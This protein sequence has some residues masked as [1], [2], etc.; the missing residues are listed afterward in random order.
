MILCFGDDSAGNQVCTV[1]FPVLGINI[2]QD[3]KHIPFLF[4][5]LIP[6]PIGRT[7]ILDF[8]TGD[9][10]KKLCCLKQFLFKF[11]RISFCQLNV[12]IGVISNQ[13]PFLLQPAHQLR[14]DFRIFPE[15]KKGSLHS[16]F[17]QTI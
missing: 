9:V 17:F 10:L 3:R 14:I 2:P 15:H 12:A 7:Y 4:V 8:L 1:A 6:C 5:G 11:F 16:S 13:M